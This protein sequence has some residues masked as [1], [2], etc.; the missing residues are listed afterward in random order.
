MSSSQLFSLLHSLTNTVRCRLF[1][2]QNT[3]RGP[4][5]GHWNNDKCPPLRDLINIYLNIYI[6]KKWRWCKWGLRWDYF[7]ATL[8]CSSYSSLRLKMHSLLSLALSNEALICKWDCPF[9]LI[10]FSAVFTAE[11]EKVGVSIGRNV[12]AYAL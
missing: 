3:S 10:S 7:E 11:C 9:S 4:S 2:L 12:T 6:Y 8:W 1:K 5:W